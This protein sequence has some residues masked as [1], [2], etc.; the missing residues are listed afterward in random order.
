MTFEVSH[1]PSTGRL[2]FSYKRHVFVALGL[3]LV[4]SGL[5]TLT[6]PW[7]QSILEALLG[8]IGIVVQERYQW[9]LAAGQI[10]PGLALLGYKHFVLD[11]DLSRIAADRN[12]VADAQIEPDKL[13]YYLSNLI[14]DH[15]YKSSL[16]SE[17]G[18]VIDHFSKPEHRLQHP[19]TAAAF[20]AFA[21]PAINL[22]RFV[23]T[24]FF[25]FPNTPPPDGDYRYCLAP[26]L[27]FDR[28]MSIY[29]ASKVAE[30]DQLK[31]RLHELVLETEAR[32]SEWLDQMKKLGNV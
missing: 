4:G 14:D 20:E 27:N 26:H 24:N 18:R 19:A 3:L 25:V 13:R 16:N 7:W 23:A 32:F 21:A 2:S 12:T 22:Q 1:D 10:F 15:S 9:A 5:A 29:D 17:F 28:E 30:Y 6:G 31:I 11:R 8:K